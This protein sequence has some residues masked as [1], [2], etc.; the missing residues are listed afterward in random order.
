M[1]YFQDRRNFLWALIACCTGRLVTAPVYSAAGTSL[2]E[3]SGNA[4]KEKLLGSWELQ[5]Y[6]YTSNNRTFSSPD[7]MEGIANFTEEGYDA[8]FSTYISAVGIKRTRRKSE[9]G[10]FSVD[11]SSIRLFAEEA[12]EE[13]EKGEEFLMDVRIEGDTMTLTSNNSSNNEVWKRS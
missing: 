2:Q 13:E 1:S 6:T 7:E 3:S 11:G 4:L 12:S 8:N 10:A 5:S 9:T